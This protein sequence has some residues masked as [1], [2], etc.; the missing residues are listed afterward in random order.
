MKS[1]QYLKGKKTNVSHNEALTSVT[2][3]AFVETQ[4]YFPP[5]MYAINETNKMEKDV[6]L[7]V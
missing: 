7:A 4:T 5:L 6:D 2:T 1:K 3:K